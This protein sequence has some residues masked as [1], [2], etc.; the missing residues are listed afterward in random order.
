MAI[1]TDML[2]KRERFISFD[3]VVYKSS[4]FVGNIIGHSPCFVANLVVIQSG[5]G[6][7]T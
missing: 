4:P 2:K 1:P 3:F 7:Y 5:P 6:K